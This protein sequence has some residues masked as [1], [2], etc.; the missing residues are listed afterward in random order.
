MVLNPA[1]SRNGDKSVFKGAPI[2][3]E[4]ERLAVWKDDF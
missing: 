3:K 1:Y 4:I 2:K